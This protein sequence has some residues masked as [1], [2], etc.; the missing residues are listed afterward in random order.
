M[1]SDFIVDQNIKTVL[2]LCPN[3]GDIK[4]TEPFYQDQYLQQSPSLGSQGK[5][6]L[7]ED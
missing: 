6:S 1:L 7:W 2:F 5:S 3:S 4:C